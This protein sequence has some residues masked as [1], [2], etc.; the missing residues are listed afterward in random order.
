M[1]TVDFESLTKPVSADA[2]CGDDLELSG[3]MDYMNFTAGAEGL[4]PK[5]YFGKD[6]SGNEDRPFDRNS[7]DFEAQFNAAKPFL[8][9]TRDLRM[10]GILAKFCILNRDFSGFIACIR[11]M[12]ALLAEHWDDVHP[13]AEDGDYSFRMVAIEAIEAFQTVIL[14]LQ[15]LPLIEHKRLGA[16]SYRNYLIAKGEVTPTEAETAID[17][18]TVE[19]VLQEVELSA[20]VERRQQVMELDAAIK[21]IRAVWMDKCSSGQNLGFERLPACVAGIFGMLDAVIGKRD[22]GAALAPA[23]GATDGQEVAAAPVNLGQVTSA[24]NAARALA[25]VAEYFGRSEPS[26]PALLLV[27]QAQDLLGKSFLEVIQLLV[28]DQVARAAVNIGKEE[29]FDLPIE[30]LATATGDSQAQGIIATELDGQPEYQFEART[31]S[32]ALALLEQVGLYF[33]AAEPSSPVPF[34]T[35]RARDLATRDFLS[36]LKALLPADAFRSI[37][38]PKAS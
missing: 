18:P 13:R 2:P 14:P 38:P 17:L 11:A 28:P 3:D 26:N 37:E 12:G 5:S 33:R 6:Q 27:R 24:A 1:A 8:E 36:V 34:F 23:T 25:A 22:P 4:L 32:D 35:D 31:R 7:I 16:I 19:K 15:F 9:R 21:Q 10:L 20:L 30:R 29:F